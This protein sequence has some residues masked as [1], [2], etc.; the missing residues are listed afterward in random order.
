MASELI[1]TIGSF[2][3]VIAES[4]L[5]W[6]VLCFFAGIFFIVVGK[7][8][9][10]ADPSQPSKGIVYIAEEMYN[11]FLYVVE[12]NLQKKSNRYLPLFGTLIFMMLLANLIGLLGVQN[13]TSNVSFNLTLALMFFFMIQYEALK[14]GGLKKRLKELAEP[15]IILLPLNIISELA[16]P[17]SLTMRLFGNILAGSLIL[18]L[19]YTAM[20]SVAPLGYLGL[21]I[22]PFLHVYF[23]VF[24]GVI[25]T[26]IFF[27]LGTYFL[28]EQINYEESN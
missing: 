10:K 13:P 8:I 18:M 15:I 11:L 19:I 26:Y 17:L 7:K 24:S 14:K 6:I 25:Q 28:G 12:G 5:V 16:L 3:L 22:T 20:Q 2:Q 1:I 9:E 21:L 27:T 4:I 23:D